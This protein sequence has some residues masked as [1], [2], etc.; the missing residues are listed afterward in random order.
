MGWRQCMHNVENAAEPTHMRSPAGSTVVTAVDGCCS[1]QP[2]SPNSGI[3]PSCSLVL[4]PFLSV[5]PATPQPH[6]Q[7]VVHR[8]PKLLL[9]ARLQHLRHSHADRGNVRLNAWT[10]GRGDV[11]LKS[12]STLPTCRHKVASMHSLHTQAAQA[13][14]LTSEIVSPSA[15]AIST[16]PSTSNGSSPAGGNMFVRE[17]EQCL[18][19]ACMVCS[20][21][22][23]QSAGCA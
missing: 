1:M 20:I 19:P 21:C 4:P 2:H 16:R 12:H 3:H 6:L 10:D 23:K 15:A 14:C 7:A 22:R 11:R 8:R 5:C 18:Q 9:H 13:R 17:V